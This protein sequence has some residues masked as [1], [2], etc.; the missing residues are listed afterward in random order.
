[1]AWV[2]IGSQ[3]E[4]RAEAAQAGVHSNWSMPFMTQYNAAELQAAPMLLQERLHTG[5]GECS[6]LVMTWVTSA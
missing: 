4:W 6:K 1:M 5:M 2:E 3:E